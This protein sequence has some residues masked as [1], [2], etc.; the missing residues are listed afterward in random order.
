MTAALNAL[1]PKP[2][3][4]K[5]PAAYNVEKKSPDRGGQGL[6][7][8][9]SY[10]IHTTRYNEL[11]E[12]VRVYRFNV[13]ELRLFLSKQPGERLGRMGASTRGRRR[14]PR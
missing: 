2:P 7:E 11:T 3:R 12:P 8:S 1:S 4:I 13:R 9:V 5:S 10:A 14:R 6:K